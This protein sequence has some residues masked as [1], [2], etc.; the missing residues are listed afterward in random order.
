MPE[1]CFPFC[2][3]ISRALSRWRVIPLSVT[4]SYKFTCHRNHKATER[5]RKYFTVPLCELKIVAFMQT[6]AYN[7][8]KIITSHTKVTQ[9]GEKY[10][11]KKVS[12]IQRQSRH[13]IQVRKRKSF[14]PIIHWS[15]LKSQKLKKRF[16][17]RC[18]CKNRNIKQ[19][20]RKETMHTLKSTL[21]S[22]HFLLLL[23]SQCIYLKYSPLAVVFLAHM[24]PDQTPQS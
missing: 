18:C 5:Q 13:F 19:S 22:A 17:Y 20:S 2:I 10:K 23:S 11:K 14:T 15:Q 21:T 3:A 6:I 1:K 16:F 8:V 4:P 9:V 7:N 24:P 12:S